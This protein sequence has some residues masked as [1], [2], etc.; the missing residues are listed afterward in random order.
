MKSL[1]KEK[2]KYPNPK[3]IYSYGKLIEMFSKENDVVLDCFIG[4]GTT[5][6]ACK[7]LNRKF[8]GFE[9]NKEYYDIANI[10]IQNSKGVEHGKK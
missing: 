6:I 7:E 1:K 8:I 4:S 5:A 2:W 9:I 10:R 3:S